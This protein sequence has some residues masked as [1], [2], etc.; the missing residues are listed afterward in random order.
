MKKQ[1]SIVLSFLFCSLLQAQQKHQQYFYFTVGSGM[2][3]LSY[4]LQ[5]GTQKGQFGSVIE[6]GYSYFFTSHFGLQS[7]VG[8]QCFG[9]RSV[10]TATTALPLVDSDGASYEFRT[11]YDNWQENQRAF[12]L[13]IPLAFQYRTSIGRKLSIQGSVG[14]KIALPINT[15]LKTTGGKLTTT[16]YYSYWDLELS[17]LPEFGF[18]STT[19]NYK[20]KLSFSPAYLFIADFGGLYSLSDKVDLYM[21]G[22]FNYGLNNILKSDSKLIYQSENDVYNGLFAANQTSRVTPMSIG[23][24]LG[25]YFRRGKSEPGLESKPINVLEMDRPIEPAVKPDTLEVL[26]ATDSAAVLSTAQATETTPTVVE[27]EPVVAISSPVPVADSNSTVSLLERIRSLASSIP[28]VFHLNSSKSEIL[29]TEKLTELSVLVNE[30]PTIRLRIV[31]HTCNMG[32]RDINLLIGKWRALC[33]ESKLLKMGIHKEQ[34]SIET[35]GSSEPL[36]PNTSEENRAK[37]RRVEIKVDQIE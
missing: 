5:N 8:V 12:F 19:T 35:K 7:G 4:T 22:Y 28:I 11:S 9:A 29:E 33:V 17:D 16:G 10:T 23:I 18:S 13:E 30:H 3:P 24:K 21:G 6:G 20:E 32:L 14:A 25:L 31:G 34:L 2:H 26:P 15:V 36:V 27:V 1:F 37:N